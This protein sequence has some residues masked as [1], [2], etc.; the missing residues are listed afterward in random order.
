MYVFLA[1]AIRWLGILKAMHKLWKRSHHFQEIH[2]LNDSCFVADVFQFKDD[3]TRSILH[4]A[5]WIYCS[6]CIFVN[7][8]L[9]DPTFEEQD[10]RN[11]MMYL[12]SIFITTIQAHPVGPSKAGPLMQA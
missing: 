1:E 4:I 9:F 3:E 5:A 10:R 6:N 8:N 11:S 7:T 12:Y 2:Y